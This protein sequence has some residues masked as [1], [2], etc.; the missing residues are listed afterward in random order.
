LE[1]LLDKLDLILSLL[2]NLLLIGSWIFTQLMEWSK[3]RV[4][5]R[6]FGAER[7]TIYFPGRNL[8]RTMPVI[9]AEDFYAAYHL[10]EFLRNHRIEVNLKHI[11][12]DANI[13]FEPG[14]IVICGPKSSPRTKEILSTDPYYKFKEEGGLWKFID[15]TTNNELLS[16]SDKQ[17]AENIDIAYFGRLQLGKNDPNFV[18]MIAGLHAIGSYGV[19]HYITN[20]KVLK[21]IDNETGN[22][23]FSTLISTYYDPQSMN[24]LSSGLQM[25]LKK[26]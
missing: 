4:V 23:R 24:I 16:P 14:S 11:P 12:V 21:Q 1:N 18:T 8:G 10:A 9:A 3:K 5:A 13:N 25:P 26:H 19:V 15:T 17:P 2:I 20:L 6:F 7:I 22:Q